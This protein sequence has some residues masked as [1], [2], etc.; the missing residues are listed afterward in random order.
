MR[1]VL[2]E[3]ND[4]FLALTGKKTQQNGEVFTRAAAMA[5][6]LHCQC[7]IWK[8]PIPERSSDPLSQHGNMQKRIKMNENQLLA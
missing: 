5:S 3:L 1:Q 2:R 4:F 7:T 8:T 6:S